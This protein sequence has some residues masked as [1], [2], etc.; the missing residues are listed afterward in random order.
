MIKFYELFGKKSVIGM[1]HLAG[2]SKK[3]KISR[4]LEEMSIYQ[5]EGISGAIIEDYHGTPNDVNE[6]LREIS[7]QNFTIVKGVN[8]L[9]NPYSSLELADSFGANF[10]QFDSVQTKDL[11]L[12]YY[13]KQRRNYPDVLVLGGVGFKYVAP[14][15]NPLVDDLKEAKSRCE[16]IVTTGEGTGIETPIDKLKQYKDLLDDF[17]LIVGAGVNLDN[18]TEQLK[19]ADGAIVGSYF[20]PHGNTNLPVERS[21]VRDLMSRLKES[22]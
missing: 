4:A 15:G 2:D 1:I 17:P 6:A 10:V 21:R 12:P 7:K 13:T 8:V 5:E 16:V 19:I 18:V 22:F 14:T 3:E 11:D 20:K 9:R